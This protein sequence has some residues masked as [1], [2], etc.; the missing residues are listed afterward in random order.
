MQDGAR[1]ISRAENMRR[2]RSKDTKPELIVR[3]LLHRNGL[4]YA[5]HDERLPGKPDIVFRT[6]RSVVQVRGCFWHGH[7]CIDGH[8]PRTRL[9]Y[10]L[11]KLAANKTRDRR[12]DK[13]LSRLGWRVL[14][15]WEC[16]CAPRRRDRLR[17]R[18]SAFLKHEMPV[19]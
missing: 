15:V 19:F 13:E 9:S 3:S 5:L 18:L 7:T 4:R 6:R 12:N 1:P 17:R 8:V 2:I 14:V 16:W 10:W 11:P